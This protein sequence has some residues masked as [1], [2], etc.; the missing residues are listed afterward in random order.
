MWSINGITY[1][2]A[3]PLEFK[4]GER[5]RITYTNRHDDESSY[6]FTWYVE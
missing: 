3:K 5:L 4:Y 2:D 1:K 6:A